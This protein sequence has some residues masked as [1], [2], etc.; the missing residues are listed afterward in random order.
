MAFSVIKYLE[1]VI[2]H[3]DFVALKFPYHG[4]GLPRSYLASSFTGQIY[5]SI[6]FIVHTPDT[7]TKIH[8]IIQDSVDA[9]FNFL[10]SLMYPWK[11]EEPALSMFIG[12]VARI[13]CFDL[14][15]APFLG[16]SISPTE[17]V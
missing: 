8:A 5:L 13:G 4:F 14:L 10:C 11:L 16:G 6:V 2:L 12:N 17:E 15:N 9:L 1:G 7:H 3:R